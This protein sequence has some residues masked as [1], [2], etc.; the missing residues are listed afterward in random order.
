[1]T[2]D[3]LVRWLQSA[4]RANE[5]DWTNETDR[6]RQSARIQEVFD[7][8]L[9][10]LAVQVPE[11]LRALNKRVTLGPLHLGTNYVDA[12][13]SIPQAIFALHQSD[14]PS[15]NAEIRA[16]AELA[17]AVFNWFRSLP[18]SNAAA[19]RIVAD[20]PDA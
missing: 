5:H 10:G 17:V 14:D 9:R 18:E 13:T 3:D 2:R 6:N 16:T 19:Q 4:L 8:A 15:V 7:L 20:V 11:E 1:M 12:G